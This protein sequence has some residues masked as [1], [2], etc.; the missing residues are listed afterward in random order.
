MKFTDP[1]DGRILTEC[2][3][4]YDK[5]LSAE[6]FYSRKAKQ[7]QRGLKSIFSD[8]LN[9]RTPSISVKIIRPTTFNH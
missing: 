4:G 5:R 3:L 9:G 6:S 7:I 2:N 8:V 1:F